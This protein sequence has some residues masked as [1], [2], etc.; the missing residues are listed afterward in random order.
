M[1]WKFILLFMG[2]LKLILDRI[3]GVEVF[4]VPKFNHIF[5]FRDNGEFSSSG[6]FNWHANWKKIDVQKFL[7]QFFRKL[8]CRTA[9]I[10]EAVGLSLN[11]FLKYSTWEWNK[12]SFLIT[13]FK[14]FTIWYCYALTWTYLEMQ[15]KSFQL[16]LN[17]GNTRTI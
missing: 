10:T 15:H 14:F 4:F 8:A 17:R 3:W 12:G 13:E 16:C 11:D 7:E 5:M 2:L 1:F 9:T 6:A